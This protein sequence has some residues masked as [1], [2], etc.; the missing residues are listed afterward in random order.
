MAK[1]SD[2]AKAADPSPRKPQRTTNKRVQKKTT[3]K[4][5]ASNKK[6]RSKREQ[7]KALYAACE[8]GL[9]RTVGQL[10]KA[11]VDVNCVEAMCAGTPL[12]AATANAHVGI[13]RDLLVA[14][15][16]PSIRGDDGIA[17]LELAAP[18]SEIEELLRAHGARGPVART[19]VS[20]ELAILMK[21]R[22]VAT[23]DYDN[24][25]LLVRESVEQVA[26][27]FVSI[28]K[29]ALWEK[30]VQNA[31]LT[32]TENCFFVFQLFGHAWSEIVQIGIADV[33]KYLR[34]SERRTRDAKAL[35]RRLK[36]RAIAYA[37]SDTAL[38]Y[39]Y[40]LYEAG[41]LLERLNA[42]EDVVEFEST[43]RDTP[44]SIK[45]VERFIDGFFRDQDAFEPGLRFA[46]IVGRISS[47]PGERVELGDTMGQFERMD[48][49]SI[50]K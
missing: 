14:G 32:L 39:H 13:V 37:V 24:S 49:V 1:K 31:E 16:D 50:R 41:K 21:A 45:N 12:L 36:T 20:P 42:Y 11:G 22:G 9:R 34:E 23:F 4:Q 35:S 33:A 25:M 2:S 29:A 38:A 47:E 46:H 48:F 19:D 18:G 6:R 26:E 7:E 17:P 8:K 44:K 10:I 30:G 3:T 28:R 15:A 5:L 43:L 40:E 27:E